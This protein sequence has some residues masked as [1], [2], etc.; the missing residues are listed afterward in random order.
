M[1]APLCLI[2]IDLVCIPSIVDCI[3]P[4]GLPRMVCLDKTIYFIESQAFHYAFALQ[5]H[6]DS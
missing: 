4:D 6:H 3:G 2:L 5:N 1:N